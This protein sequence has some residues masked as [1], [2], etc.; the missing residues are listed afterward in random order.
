MFMFHQDGGVVIQNANTGRFDLVINGVLALSSCLV[1]AATGLNEVVAE[2]TKRGFIAAK[3]W[4]GYHDGGDISAQINV[5]V[6]SQRTLLYNSGPLTDEA[7]TLIAAQEA[8]QFNDGPGY[9]NAILELG[10]D[11][12]TDEVTTQLVA[13][14]VARVGGI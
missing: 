2:A 1:D 8:A 4:Q 7:E 3:D 14:E 5:A 6:D 10:T 9:L 12:K 11:P 13:E